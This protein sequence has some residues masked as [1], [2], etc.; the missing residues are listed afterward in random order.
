MYFGV[1]EEVSWVVLLCQLV[2]CQFASQ[3]VNILLVEQGAQ[4]GRPGAEKKFGS[5][6][7]IENG[8]GLLGLTPVVLPL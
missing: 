2:R 7:G 1:V 4:L 3:M 5:F 6:G 8:K